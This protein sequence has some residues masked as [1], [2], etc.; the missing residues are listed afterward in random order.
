ME[1]LTEKF[2]AVS[3]KLYQQAQQAAGG[4]GPDMSGM[5]G[6]GGNAGPSGPSGGNDD[7][8]DADYTVVDD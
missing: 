4:A 7:F 6:M 2:H 3:T 8:V 1:V 5:G